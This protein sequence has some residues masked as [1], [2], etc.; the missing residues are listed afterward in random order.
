MIKIFIAG[1]STASIKEKSK[2]PETGWGEAFRFFLKKNVELRNYAV[3]GRS[4]K[5]FI[6]DGLLDKISNEISAGD[7]LLIQFGH[8]DEKIDDLTRYTDPIW[9]YPQNLKKYIKVARSK[10]ATP[11]LLTSVSR[12]KFNN[13]VFVKKN[14]GIYP[15]VM[16]NVAKEEAVVL[17]DM[18]QLMEEK[19]AEMGDNLSK[20]L[21][22]HIERGVHDNYPDGIADDTHFSSF[23]ALFTAYQLYLKLLDTPLSS[24]L[25]EFPIK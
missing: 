24:Y 11:I 14:I 20:K 12:R 22:L 21:F 8:N 7:F 9:E 15:E 1:D 19:I 17:I 6:T 16:R 4:T 5:S 3:N 2:Y 25:N 13:G 23:G 10:G 18:N